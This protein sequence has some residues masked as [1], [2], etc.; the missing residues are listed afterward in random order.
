MKKEPTAVGSFFGGHF[1]ESAMIKGK[2][3]TCDICKSEMPM[4]IDFSDPAAPTHDI[5]SLGYKTKSGK[6]MNKNYDVCAV[7]MEKV[8]EL[9]SGE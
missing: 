2:K 4:T 5:V 1:K 7:C 9:L 3:R 6:A 8:D